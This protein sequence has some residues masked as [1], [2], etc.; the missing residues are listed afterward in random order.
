MTLS[1][2]YG[3]QVAGCRGGNCNNT[4]LFLIIITIQRTH[5]HGHML[6]T[7]I[8]SRPYEPGTEVRGLRGNPKMA[9]EAFVNVMVVSKIFFLNG[10]H[11]VRETFEGFPQMALTLKT[12]IKIDK[13]HM[14][15]YMGSGR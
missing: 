5:S 13:R 3:I 8:D 6:W 1:T 2:R 9:M 15:Y 14:D 4:I 7:R 12:K 11:N 10:Q